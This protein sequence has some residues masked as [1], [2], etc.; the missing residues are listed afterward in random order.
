MKKDYTAETEYMRAWCITFQQYLSTITPNEEMKRV[1]LSSI[2]H[3]KTANAPTPSLTYRGMKE[4]F[5]DFVSSAK[6]LNPAQRQELN[7]ILKQQ[8]GKDLDDI[9]LEKDV[10]RIEKRG[11]INT[12]EE[13]RIID[14]AINE[15]CQTSPQSEKIQLYGSMLLAY[16]K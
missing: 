10:L 16:K 6:D 15:L 9:D 14:E 5:R 13:Y 8:F 2:E 4:A 3:F 7:A 12:D 1:Y 11:K